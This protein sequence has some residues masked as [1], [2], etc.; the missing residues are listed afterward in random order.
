[1]P[2]VTPNA[3][4]EY[5][6]FDG[7]YGHIQHH[8]MLEQAVETVSSSGNNTVSVSSAIIQALT[9]ATITNTGTISAPQAIITQVGLGGA[10]PGSAS[11][12]APVK[13][14]Y[15]TAAPI[16]VAVPAITMLG[17]TT[18]S[19][20]Q[21]FS[22]GAQLGNA[23]AVGDAVILVPTTATP[24]NV[25]IGGARVSDTNSIEVAFVGRTAATVTATFTVHVFVVDMT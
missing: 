7:E 12:A 4:N 16:A 21:T 15:R 24:S 19:V 22:V 9:G 2:D 17:V 11:T 10:T 14:F 18:V 5:A 20:I 1:M 23:A 3:P 6:V 13:G 8:R 25:G